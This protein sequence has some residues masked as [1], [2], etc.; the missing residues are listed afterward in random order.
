[1]ERSNILGLVLVWGLANNKILYELLVLKTKFSSENPSSAVALPWLAAVGELTKSSGNA[2]F[3]RTRSVNLRGKKE[4]IQGGSYC[5]L[6]PKG[7]KL[8][9]ENSNKSLKSKEL[10]NHCLKWKTDCIS[11]QHTGSRWSQSGLDMCFVWLWY[12]KNNINLSET[13]LSLCRACILRRST[14][15]TTLYCL[16]LIYLCTWCDLILQHLKY[17]FEFFMAVYDHNRKTL[18]AE[19]LRWNLN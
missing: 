9:V 17:F 6:Y 18:E 13:C 14:F 12:F 19:D 2:M 3:T 4:Q 8:Y 10:G 16:I 11:E 5:Q 7:L 15:L 1:M